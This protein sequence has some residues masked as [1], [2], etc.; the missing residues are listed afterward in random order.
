M[1][2]V[3]LCFEA[4]EA[5]AA[6]L[7]QLRGKVRADYKDLAK[8]S[9]LDPVTQADRDAE[10]LL[11]RELLG[12]FPGDGFLGEEGAPESSRSGWLWVADP[13][14]GT[15]NFAHGGGHAAVSLALLK[16]GEPVAGAIV[17]VTGESAHA[18][19]GGGA[20]RS[21]RRL[22]ASGVRHLGEALGATD[23]PYDLKLRHGSARARFI[24]L[25]EACQSVRILGS[26]ALELV[27][28]AAGELDLYANEGC[29]AWDLCAGALILNEAGGLLTAE[30]GGRLDLL[31]PG[32]FLASN[33]PLH[34]PA[35][36]CLA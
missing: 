17:P 31:E 30:D 2:R 34:G 9:T 22:Q 5:A 18:E 4:A 16:D 7:R 27:A 26:A 23:L 15:L 32:P 21:G 13:L 3:Q 24:A 14:D 10:A 33:G 1:N 12:H 25:S 28:V 19:R 8:G 6:L 29:K 20:Y 35:L 11:R 36:A